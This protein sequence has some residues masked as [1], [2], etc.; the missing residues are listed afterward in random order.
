MTDLSV[1]IV[2]NGREKSLRRC[3]KSIDRMT[4]TPYELV[5]LD[6]SKA[7]TND[8]KI[9]KWLIDKAKT[10]VDYDKKIGIGA[11]YQMVADLCD[12]NYIFHI[13]DDI[14][15]KDHAV[16][17]A[18]YKYI[19]DNPDTDII[20]CCWYDMMYKGMREVSM[21]W[22]EGWS[23]GRLSFKKQ[24]VPYEL[25]GKGAWGEAMQV[26]KSDECLHSMIVNKET[27]YDKGI[28]WDPNLPSKG[29]REAF[30]YKCKQADIDIRVLVDQIVI[31]DPEFYEHGSETYVTK[32]KESKDYFYKTYGY[33]PIMYWDKPQL[34]AG[35]DGKP[36][37]INQDGKI[38]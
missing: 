35:P 3:I 1:A 4:K 17:D 14:Y 21:K 5:L 6:V 15:L 26:V 28:K 16:V 10:Y 30:F 20:S 24:L 12:T 32:G 23:D 38:I 19:K 36:V 31:H 8:V 13:D 37:Y 29:D 22:L 25:A 18:E 9:P 27:V 11:G 34:R 2:T 33:W 7:F